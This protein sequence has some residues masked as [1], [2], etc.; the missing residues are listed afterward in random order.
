MCASHKSRWRTIT[1][2][3]LENRHS[4]G[5][6]ENNVSP[7][8]VYDILPTLGEALGRFLE[9]RGFRKLDVSS[10]VL[11]DGAA[12]SP[13]IQWYIGKYLSEFHFVVERSQRSCSPKAT[14]Y[15]RRRYCTKV[16]KANHR[17]RKHWG[18][19]SDR[20]QPSTGFTY[21]S[22]ICQK[23]IHSLDIRKWGMSQEF[24]ST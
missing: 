7:C 6:S 4:F 18:S 12:P 8:F 17:L 3:S 13:M 19:G 2:G 22:Q 15:R 5:C 20:S 9:D 1:A 23:L 10:S 21:A 16:P 11:V 24:T 14:S